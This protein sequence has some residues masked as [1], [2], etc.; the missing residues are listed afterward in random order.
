MS[1]KN[2]LVGPSVATGPWTPEMVWDTGFIGAYAGNMAALSVEQYVFRYPNTIILTP[3]IAT[4]M[5]TASPSSASAR[6]K[7]LKQSSQTI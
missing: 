2:N 6:P 5:T 7:T 1:V 4:P 3:Y